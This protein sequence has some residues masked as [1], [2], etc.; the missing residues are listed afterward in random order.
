MITLHISLEYYLFIEDALE[1]ILLSD[2]MFFKT[3]LNRLLIIQHVHINDF[4]TNSHIN[5]YFYGSSFS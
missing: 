5:G 2:E 4:K 3:F 1:G